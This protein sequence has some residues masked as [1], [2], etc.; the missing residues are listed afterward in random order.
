V[1]IILAVVGAVVAAIGV[2]AVLAIYGVRKYIANAKTAEARNSVGQIAKDA[3]AAYEAER[4]PSPGSSAAPGHRVCPSASRPVPVE[5]AM[6]SGKKYQSAAG[7]WA[8]D[9]ERDAG[10]ACL[11]FEMTAPQYYQYRYEATASSFTAG[12][13][14]DLNGDGRFSEFQLQG[15]I[16]YKA[17]VVTPTL[18]EFDPEE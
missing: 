17:L 8:V 9:K 3:V 10:F 15:Q 5:A 1:V 18:L 2:M 11:R 6:I 13:R 4:L 7:E 14:G 12:G 16:I